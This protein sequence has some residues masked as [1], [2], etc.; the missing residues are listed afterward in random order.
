[1]VLVLLDA[2]QGFIGSYGPPLISLV[3][4]SPRTKDEKNSRKR[5]TS[6]Y[7][8]T[9]AR[10]QRT[11]WNAPLCILRIISGDRSWRWTR[12]LRPCA[13]GGTLQA[14]W[15][16]LVAVCHCTRWGSLAT[17]RKYVKR[18]PFVRVERCTRRLEALDAHHQ[19]M[20]RCRRRACSALG[21]TRR[22]ARSSIRE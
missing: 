9:C 15:S 20:V 18:K 14:A 10:T 8:N 21:D 2:R 4:K 19:T 12:V 16:G 3:Q 11:L 6:A 7:S 22:H 5:S 1:M 17:P 13:R